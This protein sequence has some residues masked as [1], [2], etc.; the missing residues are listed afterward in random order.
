MTAG[1]QHRIYP[2]RLT[3]REQRDR[4]WRSMLR[5]AYYA[6]ETLPI[7]RLRAGESVVA[8]ARDCGISRSALRDRV[9]DAALRVQC[10]LA[11][12]R[13]LHGWRGAKGD[14]SGFG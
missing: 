1:A 11:Q 6:D 14:A 12:W 5:L 9:R 7:A 3:K 4:E 10:W 2:P 13:R 8:I